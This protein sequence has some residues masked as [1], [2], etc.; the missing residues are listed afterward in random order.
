[1]TGGGSVI[2]MAKYWESKHHLERQQR[3]YY[4]IVTCGLLHLPGGI[5]VSPTCILCIDV[6][7]PRMNI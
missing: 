1:M 4:C 5:T 3:V 2:F 7:F 6:E